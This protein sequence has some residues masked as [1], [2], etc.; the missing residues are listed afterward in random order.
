VRY[1]LDAHGH[2]EYL[3]TLND[4]TIGNLRLRSVYQR[5]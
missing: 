2:L 1:Q 4:P 5:G 3:R